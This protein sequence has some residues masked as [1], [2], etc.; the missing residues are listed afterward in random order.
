M[1]HSSNADK[2]SGL[3]LAQE[4]LLAVA[5]RTD[6]SCWSKADGRRLSASEGRA[7]VPLRQ[8]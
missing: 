5:T 1:L 8:R 3:P 4:S 7:D 2:L 6:V